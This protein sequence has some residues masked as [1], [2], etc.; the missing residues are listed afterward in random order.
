MWLV[1]IFSLSL[2]AEVIVTHTNKSSTKC[3]IPCIRGDQ[4]GH[5]GNSRH[6]TEERT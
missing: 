5:C 3:G 1:E 2:K 6:P 4:V